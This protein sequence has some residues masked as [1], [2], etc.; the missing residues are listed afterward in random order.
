MCVSD[1]PLLKESAPFRLLDGTDAYIYVDSSC[2]GVGRG[3]VLDIEDIKRK[4]LLLRT[5][6]LATDLDALIGWYLDENE[7]G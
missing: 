7:G 3:N 5:Q 4:A 1:K 2:K 6:A